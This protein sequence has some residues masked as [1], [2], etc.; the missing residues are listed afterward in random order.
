MATL[1]TGDGVSLHYTDDG[2]GRP[3]VFIS[4]W[5]MSGNW[6]AEQRRRFSRTNRVLVLDTRAQGQSEKVTRGHRLSRHATDL[7]DFLTALDLRDVTLIGWSRG[8]S[9]VMSYL[10]LF[11]MDRIDGLV[12]SGFLPSL[13]ARPDWPWGFNVPPQ[14]FIDSV[15][16]D[17]ASVVTNMIPNMMHKKLDPAVVKSLTEESL[18]VPPIA[19]ARM[20]HDH[21]NIDWRDFLPFIDRPALIVVGAHDPQ[22]PVEAANASAALMPSARVAVS[23]ESGH[24]PFIEEPETFN[25]ELEAFL[26][27]LP[28]A[29]I[30]RP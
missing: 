26:A 13:A 14:Q 22:A 24:C 28:E 20:L 30:T 17:Y 23:P 10:E 16:A 1:K 18:K 15:L 3:L 4:G 8:T 9:V 11:G 29:E 21:M 19:A 5:A 7:N 27:L 2:S 25:R 6:W 12:L